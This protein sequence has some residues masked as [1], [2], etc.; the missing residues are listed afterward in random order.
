MTVVYLFYVLHK[1]RKPSVTIY[2]YLSVLFFL[3]TTKIKKRKI[4]MKIILSGKNNLTFYIMICI[5]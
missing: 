2:T 3:Y 4:F 5:L 1:I